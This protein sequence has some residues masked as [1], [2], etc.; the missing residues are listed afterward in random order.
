M[1][2]DSILERVE[3]RQ[4]LV[5]RVAVGRGEAPRIVSIDVLRGSV[6][7]VIAFFFGTSG[8]NPAM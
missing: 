6:M 7:A 2:R 8:F 5:G 1:H 4:S 3:V